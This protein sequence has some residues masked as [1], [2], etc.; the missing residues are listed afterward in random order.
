[1]YHEAQISSRTKIQT[2]CLTGPT[3]I[4]S[5]TG[6]SSFEVTTANGDNRAVPISQIKPYKDDILENGAPMHFYRPGHREAPFATPEI[7]EIL[8]HRVEDK[9]LPYFWYIGQGP[10]RAGLLAIPAGTY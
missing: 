8:S 9:R 5:R 3:T 2:Y 1:M 7:H 10:L 6:A 4:T